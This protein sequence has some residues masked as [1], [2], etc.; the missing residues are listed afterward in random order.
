MKRKTNFKNNSKIDRELQV[1]DFHVDTN[2][3]PLR[4]II[5]KEVSSYKDEKIIIEDDFYRKSGGLIFFHSAD[6]K[7]YVDPHKK[8]LRK[9]K[10]KTKSLGNRQ[11]RRR[12][13]RELDNEMATS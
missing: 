10:R 7:G 5:E 6:E 8:Q 12:D 2:I 1:H 4:E 3:N 11:K 13:N 9:E